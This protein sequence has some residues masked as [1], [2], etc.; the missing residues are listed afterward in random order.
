M[1]PGNWICRCIIVDDLHK[2]FMAATEIESNRKSAITFDMIELEGRLWC[3]RKV[4]NT[5][6]VNN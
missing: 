1:G 2:A 6:N 4:I 3:Q 5:L